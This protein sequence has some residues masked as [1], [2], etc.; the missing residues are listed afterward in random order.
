MT[1]VTIKTLEVF[2]NNNCAQAT[3]SGI[4]N[5]YHD[6]DETMFFNTLVGFG[7]G[8]G[9]GSLCGAISG[10]IAAMSKILYDRKV[11]KDDIIEARNQLK[12]K[13]R[14]TFEFLECRELTQDYGDLS[15][16]EKKASCIKIGV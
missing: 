12:E 16:E 6:K 10:T 3:A 9:E 5:H 4:L 13:F 15:D 7:G 11:P 14:E 1:D 8:F 2:E